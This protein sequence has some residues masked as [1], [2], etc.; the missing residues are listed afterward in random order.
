MVFR[1]RPLAGG[2][3]PFSGGTRSVPEE[4]EFS[5]PTRRYVM[6]AGRSTK[7]GQQINVGKDSPEYQALVTTIIMNADD[8]REVGINPGD[9]VR[10]KA[11][12]GEGIFYCKD[13]KV[14]TG[15]VFVCYGPPTCQ[16]MGYITDGTGMPQSKG[17]EVEVE[18]APGLTPPLIGPDSVIPRY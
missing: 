8:M 12:N 6:N 1:C 9:S 15:M 4:S 10:V 3:L 11:D 13:G 18:L 16:L 14:P 2:K 7:Q 17:W 5:V